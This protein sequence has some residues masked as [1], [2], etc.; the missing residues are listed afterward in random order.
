MQNRVS[1]HGVS[2][3]ILDSFR[4]PSQQALPDFH[5]FGSRTSKSVASF[6]H[7][8]LTSLLISFRSFFKLISDCTEPQTLS[9]NLCQNFE[10]RWGVSWVR[11]SEIEL[12]NSGTLFHSLP[13]VVGGLRSKNYVIYISITLCKFPSKWGEFNQ[14]NDSLGR[15][16][17][18]CSTL[19]WRYF[20]YSSANRRN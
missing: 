13:V 1:G 4:L 11:P 15:K 18:Q 17:F 2:Q 19:N 14:N 9:W 5:T 6:H 12:R 10:N 20:V 16:T 3:A 7:S 8:S